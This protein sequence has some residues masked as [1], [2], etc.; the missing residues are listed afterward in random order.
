MDLSEIC[1][2]LRR[3][4]K[5][6]TP[7]AQIATTVDD[8]DSLWTP[9][10]P[11]TLSLDYGDRQQGAASTKLSVAAAH[12]TG[13][14]C[15]HDIP[16]LSLTGH[17]WLRFWIKSSIDLAAGELAVLLDGSGGCVTPER[18][19]PVPA[20]LAGIWYEH[21]I[22]IGD[23]SGLETLMSLGLSVIVDKGDMLVWLDNVRAI[24]PAFRWSDEELERHAL[25][26][27]KE[28]S[29]HIPYEMNAEVATAPGSFKVN[30][31]TLTG[32][33]KVFAVEYPKD[34][35]PPSL[36]RFSV[37]QDTITL[38]GGAVPDGS[39]CLVRYGALHTLDASSCTLPEYL[40]DILALGAQGYALQAF[41]AAAL[42]PL[43]ADARHAQ[44]A[45]AQDAR[46]LLTD[47][48]S[49]L[50]QLSYRGRLR[51]ASMY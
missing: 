44:E 50:R 17:E 26:A 23:T 4:L 5:D 32:R 1:T 24:R 45:A 46:L 40:E 18:T 33:V 29:Y 49:Q 21:Q 7:L 37:W 25:R 38:L 9:V 28:I 13:M 3:D 12:T 15:Y 22:L 16:P 14:A 36:Q 19:L 43:Q 30:I 35:E 47:F 10:A 48:R 51:P 27:L 42:D 41:A 8:C 31:A 2:R 34:Q 39:P 6:E 20:T 11:N